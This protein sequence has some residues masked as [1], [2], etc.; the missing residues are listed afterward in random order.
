MARERTDLWRTG[1]VPLVAKRKVRQTWREAVALRAG[2]PS[3]P[4]ARFDS[5]CVEGSEEAEAAYRALEEAGL[6]WLA[7]EPGAAAPT[8]APHGEVPAV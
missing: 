5:L 8:T 6:L 4:L 7:D 1:R 2:D 3:S